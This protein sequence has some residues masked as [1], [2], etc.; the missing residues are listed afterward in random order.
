MRKKLTGILDLLPCRELGYKDEED[1]IRD[2]KEVE[3]KK[4]KQI[5]LM[6]KEA[7]LRDRE[8]EVAL[9]RNTQMLDEDDD[10]FVGEMASEDA[11]KMIGANDETAAKE[12]DNEEDEEMAMARQLEQLEDGADG[13]EEYEEDNDE[14][15]AVDGSSEEVVSDETKST[16]ESFEEKM[17]EDE[18]VTD[19]DTTTKL[20]EDIVTSGSLIQST[21]VTPSCSNAEE[22]SSDMSPE[23]GAFDMN[24]VTS[25]FANDDDELVEV[26]DAPNVSRSS[27][28][29]TH[30]D[31]EDALPDTDQNLYDHVDDTNLSNASTTAPEEQA[32]SNKPKNS[33]WQAIL[34]KEKAALAKEKRRQRKNGGLV[35]AEAE[36][37]EEEEGIV[38][39]EDFGFSVSKK[40]DDDEEDDGDV[41]QD[42][43]DHVVDDVSDGEGDEEAGEVARKRLEQAEEKERHKEIIR[44]MREGYDGRRGGI[45]SGV[46]GARGTLRFD[47]LVAADNR[48]DAKRLGLLNDDELNSDDEQD[49]N[50]ETKKDD[51][52]EDEAALLGKWALGYDASMICMYIT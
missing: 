14:E 48:G 11:M 24:G 26:N 32:T 3:E 22:E 20:E 36:E 4:R 13:D 7:A 29:S 43:L 21:A 2:C 39:L 37:E 50:K 17:V 46:G 28:E 9:L 18:N 38:G 8:R 33:A 15:S 30:M 1:H 35:E 19:A 49:E 41:D 27:R 45:A 23:E 40:K 25:D 52:E 42:D 16:V 51:E 47:Q 12:Y 6:E 10:G 5:L 31:E 44:R 34:L